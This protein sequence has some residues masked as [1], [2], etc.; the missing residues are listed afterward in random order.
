M[1]FKMDSDS[2]LREAGNGLMYKF[3]HAHLFNW[4]S[5]FNIRMMYCICRLSCS[6]LNLYYSFNNSCTVR[7]KPRTKFVSLTLFHLISIHIVLALLLSCVSSGYEEEQRLFLWSKLYVVF[8]AI[9][10][11]FVLCQAGT[12]FCTSFK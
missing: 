2:V 12:E 10:S 1:R 3:L 11:T 7:L 9:R 4:A 5:N 8:C 6:L